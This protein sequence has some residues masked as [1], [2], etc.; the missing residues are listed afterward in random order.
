MLPI[1][2]NPY[3]EHPY[4]K[5][6]NNQILFLP[7]VLRLRRKYGRCDQ[8]NL[9]LPSTDDEESEKSEK[10]NSINPNK[11]KYSSSSSKDEKDSEEDSEDEDESES[12]DEEVE[13][14]YTMRTLPCEIPT[15]IVCHRVGCKDEHV[16]RK[17]RSVPNIDPEDILE[18][19][20]IFVESGGDG[21][22]KHKLSTEI[23]VD[24]GRN[25]A[26]GD[27]NTY[28]EELRKIKEYLV[29]EYGGEDDSD[30][31]D[32]KKDSKDVDLRDND[33]DKY[34]EEQLKEIKETISV[35]SD[36]KSEEFILGEMN[37]LL[38]EVFSQIDRLYKD[39][40]DE[41]AVLNFQPW[42]HKECEDFMEDSFISNKLSRWNFGVVSYVSDVEDF[43]EDSFISLELS[44][45]DFGFDGWYFSTFFLCL[46]K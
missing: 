38:P 44:Q 1:S 6:N 36:S 21:D 31:D 8:D 35:S 37:S 19:N 26:A 42:K 28:E 10:K 33:I 14:P 2:V 12:E 5:Q 13:K 17:P 11:N 25:K 15:C 46:G 32:E 34:P 16:K 29:N 18:G 24:N 22:G 23:E 9:S 45:C 4:T 3:T 7:A 30:T 27:G 39:V 41:E 40:V 43:L 20:C